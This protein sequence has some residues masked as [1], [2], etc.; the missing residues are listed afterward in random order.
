MNQASVSIG[1]A[2]NENEGIV[3]V[4]AL[5]SIPGASGAYQLGFSS[6]GPDLWLMTNEPEECGYY[7]Q[8]VAGN[9]QPNYVSPTHCITYSTTY[10]SGSTET[11]NSSEYHTSPRVSYPLLNG[12]FYFRVVGVANSTQ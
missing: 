8:L 6:S 5:K 11:T 3:I 2:S 4:Y 12:N 7:G 10:M 9:G 1:G